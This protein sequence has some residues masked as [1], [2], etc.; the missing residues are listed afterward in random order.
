MDVSAQYVNRAAL[1]EKSEIIGTGGSPSVS[2]MVI[3]GNYISLSG[4]K[5]GK[6]LVSFG[7][8]HHTVYDLN[9]SFG[10][11]EPGSVKAS[12]NSVFSVC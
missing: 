12:V 3:S 5:L 4:K 6:R 11:T 7:I 10:S 2:E 8:I 1:S 9:Y